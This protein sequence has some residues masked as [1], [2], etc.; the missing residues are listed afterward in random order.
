M[1][2]YCYYRFFRKVAKGDLSTPKTLL[3]KEG[4]GGIWLATIG[5][6]AHGKQSQKLLVGIQETNKNNQ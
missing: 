4:N 3:G 5:I 6:V 1:L 2:N